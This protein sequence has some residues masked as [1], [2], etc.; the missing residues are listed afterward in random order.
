MIHEINMAQ[1]ERELAVRGLMPLMVEVRGVSSFGRPQLPGTILLSLHQIAMDTDQ[2]FPDRGRPIVL[3]ADNED[4]IDLWRSAYFL[5]VLGYRDLRV[6]RG[7]K[8]EWLERNGPMEYL[9]DQSA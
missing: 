3:F 2:F 6:F 8:D 9:S 5:D 1:L 7:G 4:V